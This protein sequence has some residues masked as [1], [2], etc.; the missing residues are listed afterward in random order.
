[1]YFKLSYIFNIAFLQTET[2]EC[3]DTLWHIQSPW[4]RSLF[5]W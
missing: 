1:V 3:E 2:G 4:S 5:V